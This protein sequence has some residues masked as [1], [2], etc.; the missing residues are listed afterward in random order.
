M[1]WFQ[2]FY[3]D[4]AESQLC[5]WLEVLPGQ[6]RQWQDSARHSEFRH[7]LRILGQLPEVPASALDIKNSV[8]IGAPGDVPAGTQKAIA[9]LLQKFHPWRKGPYHVHGVHIDTE[10]RSDWKWDRV[11]PHLSPLKNRFVLDV[12][13]GSGYHMWRMLGEGAWRVVGID[14]SDLFLI[15][16]Q[17]IKHF[18][19][20]A[21]PDLPI[22][23]L[24]L[25]IQQMPAL[26]AFD[27]VF[28]MGVLYHR[29]SPIE[30]IEQL[31]AQL[32]D[33]GELVLE[34]LVIDGDD[35]AV[36]V[37]EDRYAQMRNV[38]FLPSAKALCRWV[39]RCGF[40]DIR[41][42]DIDQTSTGEQR[43]TDWMRNESLADFLDPQDPNKTIEG[44][45]APKR[46][47]LIATAC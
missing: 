20:A 46:A 26:H 38:W 17:A 21:R 45:P 12:G 27:T 42:V 41:I 23:L 1:N 25:G 14:P 18:A 28:S 5:H 11:L 40:S 10:W 30:H 4:I 7:W 47:V 8:T 3:A 2:R 31:R 16:F 33:G 29:K 9:G 39:S 6:L 19:R 36:L 37:P 15:Q 24:P 35:T 44:H 43:R 32:K 13:C 34:T 22:D